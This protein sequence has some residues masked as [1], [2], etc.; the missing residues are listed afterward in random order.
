M[1]ANK[2]NIKLAP[3]Y[4]F[5]RNFSHLYSILGMIS[6]HSSSCFICQKIVKHLGM[7]HSNIYNMVYKK[8][9]NWDGAGNQH[10]CCRWDVKELPPP[11]TTYYLLS[12]HCDQILVTH[13]ELDHLQYSRNTCPLTTDNLINNGGQYKIS[14]SS[15]YSPS[16]RTIGQTSYKSQ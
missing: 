1:V 4:T 3:N 16:S 14:S 6:Q 11:W 8:I 7:Q 13:I 2:E 12:C 15:S 10:P 5:S 9:P